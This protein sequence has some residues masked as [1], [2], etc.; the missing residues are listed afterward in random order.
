MS[1][2]EPRPQTESPG[3]LSG[4]LAYLG[5]SYVTVGMLTV[6]VGL[7]VAILIT[8]SGFGGTASKDADVG[9]KADSI[10]EARRQL[11]HDAD[12]GACRAALQQINVALSSRPDDRPASIDP[13]TLKRLTQDLKLDEDDGAEVAADA[14]TVLDGQHLAGAFLF[15]DA[16]AHA[17]EPQLLGA[18]VPPQARPTPLERATAAFEWAVREV[19]LAPPTLVNHMPTKD[20]FNP[21]PPQYVLRAAPARRWNAPSSS[22]TCSTRSTPPARRRSASPASI[23]RI[24][25]SPSRTIPAR[26]RP[27]PWTTRGSAWTGPPA[28]ASTT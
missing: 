6:G 16:A 27:F 21:T 12:V 8:L 4:V 22:S 13:Q 24:R 19:R 25:R 20:V 3:L 11:E 26:R 14:Y 9:K 23:R 10:D 17:L 5:R 18:D 15:R 7:I 1:S 2:G 28:R